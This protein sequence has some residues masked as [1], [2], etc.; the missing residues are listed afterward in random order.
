MRAKQ[1][2]LRVTGIIP[3]VGIGVMAI[4][5]TVLTLHI[6]CVQNIAVQ[7]HLGEEVE[8][9]VIRRPPVGRRRVDKVACPNHCVKEP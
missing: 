5:G 3:S 2:G 7:V 1:L 6:D 9:A 4:S 8:P